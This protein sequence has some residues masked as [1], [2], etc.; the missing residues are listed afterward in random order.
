MTTKPPNQ[1][2]WTLL[3]NI[4]CYTTTAIEICSEL[5]FDT[6]DA[7]GYLTPLSGLESITEGKML[8]EEKIR[9][10]EE[11]LAA[12]ESSLAGAHRFTREIQAM[13]SD[14]GKEPQND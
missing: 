8:L 11:S 7:F 5:T 1:Q 9:E 2:I 3:R 4:N 12:A 14:Q 6:S 13:L 10:I